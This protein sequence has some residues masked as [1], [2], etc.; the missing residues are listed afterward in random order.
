MFPEK[1]KMLNFN[2]RNDYKQENYAD[3]VSYWSV[4]LRKSALITEPIHTLDM[5]NMNASLNMCKLN[6]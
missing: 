5:P 1:H 2:V 3:N 6:H 4:K